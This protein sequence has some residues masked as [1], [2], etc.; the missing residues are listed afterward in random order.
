MK[1]E[2]LLPVI[3]YNHDVMMVMMVVVM[4]KYIYNDN[5]DNNDSSDDDASDND[6]DTLYTSLTW[7]TAQPHHLPVPKFTDLR[8]SHVGHDL[9]LCK[10]FENNN[11]E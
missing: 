7:P 11:G 3:R 4:M 8:R 10:P 2:P 9:A 5:H 1:Y 6:S